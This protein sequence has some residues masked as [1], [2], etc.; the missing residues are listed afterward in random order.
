MSSQHDSGALWS[1]Q[2]HMPSIQGNQLVIT[3]GEGSYVWTATGQRLLDGTSGLWYANIGHGRSELAEAAFRQMKKLETYHVFG[4]FVND[5]ARLLAERL[6]A[7]TPV[8]NPKIIFNSG[9]SDAVDVACKLARRYWQVVGQGQRQI[10]LSR[11]SSYHGLHAYGTSIGGLPYNTEG[12]GTHSLVSDTV[13]VP[14]NDLQALEQTI[15]AL[16]PG[17]I[18]AM[19]AEPVLGAGGVIGPVD[20]YFEG[21]ARLAD[22]YGFLIVA[23]EVITGFGRT[24]VMYASQRYGIKPDIMLMAKGLTSGYAPLGGVQVAERIWTEF[25]DRADA[26]VFRHGITYSGHATACAVAQANLDVLEREGLIGRAAVLETHL[27][28]ALEEFRGHP[29]VREIRSGHGF[30]A[31]LQLCE[32]VDAPAFIQALLD[33]GIILRLL[34]DNIVVIAPPFTLED[35]EI[36]AIAR[37][38]RNALDEATERR[39]VSAG[40]L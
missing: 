13:R 21:L 18:A 19:V 34:H 33:D 7:N 24:G 11:E 16:A 26:P 31:A 29:L 10:I 37:S 9:G 30:F 14:T 23:D 28:E 17:R 40:T 39:P 1:A 25:Y 15:L 6:A 5:Q 4:R 2:A 12:Y 3:R 35:A 38:I 32:E 27:V 36:S 20:G 22:R 8:D